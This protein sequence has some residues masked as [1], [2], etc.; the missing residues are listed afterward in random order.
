LRD[1]IGIDAKVTPGGRAQF[2][3]V[4][5]DRLVWSKHERGRFPDDGEIAALLGTSG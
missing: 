2:D 1:A 3:V 4:V 5:D